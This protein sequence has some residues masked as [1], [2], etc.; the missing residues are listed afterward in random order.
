MGFNLWWRVPIV[1]LLP[2]NPRHNPRHAARV[3]CAFPVQVATVA[4]LT[5][6]ST[7]AGHMRMA[8]ASWHG[9]VAACREASVE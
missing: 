6:P 8:G 7:S 2:R 1:F 3:P 5:D 4:C 9:A